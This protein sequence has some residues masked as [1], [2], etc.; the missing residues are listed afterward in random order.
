MTTTTSPVATSA[1][2]TTAKARWPLELPAK[3]VVEMLLE[4]AM[5]K[6]THR[7]APTL[8]TLVVE[9]AKDRVRNHNPHSRPKATKAGISCLCASSLSAAYQRAVSRGFDTSNENRSTL[10]CGLTHSLILVHT[11]TST[12]CAPV[13]CVQSH[14]KTKACMHV[15]INTWYEYTRYL[16]S[17]EP[18]GM[19]VA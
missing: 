17:V 16:V 19:F 6:R 1:Q 5:A 3:V 14:P 12:R 11:G 9:V 13:T 8:A 2:K 15:Y 10:F 18:Q 4:G 7:S